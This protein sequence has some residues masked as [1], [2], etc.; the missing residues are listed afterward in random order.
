MIISIVKSILSNFEP[1]RF[2]HFLD[3]YFISLDRV[4]E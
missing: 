4:Y 1:I 3:F 2:P